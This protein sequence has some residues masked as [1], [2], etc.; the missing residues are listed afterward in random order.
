[1]RIIPK[2]R[3]RGLICGLIVLALL[4]A[5]R[6]AIAQDEV[7]LTGTV[8][9]TSINTLTL[10][11]AAGQFQLFVFARNVRKPAVL[12]VGAQV[13]VV[14]SPGNEPNVRVANEVT[15]LDP[16]GAN[17]G[18][19]TASVVP[20]EIRRIER[21][22]ERQVRRFQVGVRGGVAL[23]PELV[24]IG[25]QAQIGPFFRSD[26]FF[27]P[28]VEFA[29]GEVTSMFGINP[30]VVYRLPLSSEHDRWSTYVGA[31]LGINLLHQNFDIESGGKKIDFGDFHSDTALNILGGVRYRSGMFMELKTS[32]YSDPSP[33]LR[34]IIGYNF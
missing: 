21:D 6:P 26:V 31:G 18:T 30:E 28:N 13:R 10:R 17:Q 22:I 1:M 24:L 29:V 7:A 4:I 8:A 19:A 32:V 20:P 15:V 27:R 16:A 9:S 34:L 33:K 23:D 5:G 2:K 12:P 14:S 3:G 11:N 25:V